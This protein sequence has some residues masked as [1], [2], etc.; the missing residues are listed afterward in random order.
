M[1]HHYGRGNFTSI[2]YH[3]VQKRVQSSQMARALYWARRRVQY[4]LRV[5]YENRTELLVPRNVSVARITWAEDRY[6]LGKRR[7]L[8]AFN[9]YAFIDPVY[10]KAPSYFCS[11]L[12]WIN[13][14]V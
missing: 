11:L 2:K 9:R 3:N 7:S 6:G 10:R 1:L 12:G 14:K 13:R 8:T 5:T 4:F